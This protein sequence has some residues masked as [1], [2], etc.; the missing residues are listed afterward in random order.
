MKKLGYEDVPKGGIQLPSASFGVGGEFGVGGKYDNGERFDL[1]LPY[2]ETGWVE[3]EEVN[4]RSR[5]GC[6]SLG[7]IPVS[8][9]VA[10]WVGKGGWG[11]GVAPLGTREWCGACK[12]GWTD[13]L[14]A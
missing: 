8:Q 14:A 7:S 11:G 4:I 12:L 9:R 5:P 3:G 2:V 10:L 13:N 1:R 6:A